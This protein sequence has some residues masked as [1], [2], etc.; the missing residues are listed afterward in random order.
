MPRQQHPRGKPVSIVQGVERASGPVWTSEEILT[1]SGFRT[2]N[3]RVR[4]LNEVNSCLIAKVRNI[5]NHWFRFYQGGNGRPNPRAFLR[6]CHARCCSLFTTAGWILGSIT[7]Y[8]STLRNSTHCWLFWAV[9]QSLQQLRSILYV[10]GQHDIN[11]STTNLL[12]VS[13]S[14]STFQSVL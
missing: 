10:Q 9:T 7:P 6:L 8:S 14:F 13:W 5:R 2:P 4:N 12:V 3:N 1:S 11:L